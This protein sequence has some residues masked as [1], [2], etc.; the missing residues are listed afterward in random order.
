MKGKGGTH[1]NLIKSVTLVNRFGW[2]RCSNQV[3]L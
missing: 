3:H 1:E 2:A